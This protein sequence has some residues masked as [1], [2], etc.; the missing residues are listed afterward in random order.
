MTRELLRKVDRAFVLEMGAHPVFFTAVFLTGVALA[1]A[2]AA[3]HPGGFGF[4]EGFLAEAVGNLSVFW[5]L[6]AFFFA[7]LYKKAARSVSREN[8]VLSKAILTRRVLPMRLAA[9]LSALLAAVL[10]L[11]PA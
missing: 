3:A 7:W 1:L 11:C 4:H 2:A 9:L 10:L 6:I 5:A 8:P